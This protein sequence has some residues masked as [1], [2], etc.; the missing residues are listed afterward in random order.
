MPTTPPRTYIKDLQPPARVAGVFAVQNLQLAKTKTG[1]DYLKMVLADK[2]GGTPGRKW[3]SSAKEAADLAGCGFVYIEGQS[4]AY[5]GEVQVVVERIAPHTPTQAEMRDLLPSTRK[6]VDQMFRQLVALL[7]SL[8]HPAVKA[9]ADRYLEDGEL[10]DKF[11]AAPAAQTIHH[12]FLGGL[13]EHTLGLMQMAELLL[14]FYPGLNRD[15]V[16][17][18]LFLHDVGK[19]RELTWENGFGYTTEGQLVG[20][21]AGGAILLS[22]KAKACADAELGAGAV[23][24]PDNILLALT[25]IILSHHGKPEFGAAKAPASPEAVFVSHLDDLDAKMNI[26]M[27]VA[28]R[29]EP[30]RDTGGAF[31]EK[32]W[33]LDNVRLWRPDPTA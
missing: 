12:A 2:S 32:Q 21:V 1:G 13:L 8:K 10:M 29:G 22:H 3:S 24:V 33:A 25:H 14:P 31:S 20:H 4:Q 28:G 19:C 18:G 9:L 30:A 27:T 5:Q 26:V 11:C 17:L 7:T 6:D 23:E 16:L 15:I